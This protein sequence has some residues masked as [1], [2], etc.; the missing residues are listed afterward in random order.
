MN[1]RLCRFRRPSRTRMVQRLAAGLIGRRIEDDDNPSGED[2]G[3]AVE[4][5]ARS[6]SGRVVEIIPRANERV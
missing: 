5:Q 2:F 3:L 4:K 1:E 6:N